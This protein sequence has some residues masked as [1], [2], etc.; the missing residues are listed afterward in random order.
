MLA[1]GPDCSLIRFQP[2]TFVPLDPGA[3]WLIF[4]SATTI[5]SSSLVHILL[6]IAHLHDREPSEVVWES[7]GDE[8]VGHYSLIPL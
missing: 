1:D 4:G 7:L 3:P 5:G 6:Y 2:C 8:I